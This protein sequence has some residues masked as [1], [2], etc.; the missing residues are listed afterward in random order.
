M[1]EIN[2][3]VA[4]PGN[5]LM[6]EGDYELVVKQA[7]ETAT[8]GGAIYAQI[9]L[10]IRND[11]EQQYKNKYIFHSMFKVKA[12]Q[13]YHPGITSSMCKALGIPNGTKFADY[14]ALLENLNG[15]IA[16][17]TIKHEEYNGETKEKVKYWNE[18]K[19]PEC[20]HVFKTKEQT[21]GAMFLDVVTDDLPF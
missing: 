16:R 20:K 1:F 7:I 13:E 11:V 6:K 15:K 5:G 4:Q 3:D 21:S 17:V 12:T 9:T 8:K 18:T 14:N 19:F 10:I 2:Y